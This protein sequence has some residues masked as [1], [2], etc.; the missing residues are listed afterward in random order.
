MAK[1]QERFLKHEPL[2]NDPIREYIRLFGYFEEDKTTPTLQID[3]R[4]HTTLF[5]Y[6]VWYNPEQV[7]WLYKALEAGEHMATLIDGDGLTVWHNHPNCRILL[8]NKNGYGK[9][10][11]LDAC[12]RTFLMDHKLEVLDFMKQTRIIDKKCT[13]TKNVNSQ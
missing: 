8:I 10:I 3:K 11:E 1:F 4:S 7:E 5:G 12:Q 6:S 13:V 2:R 9:E